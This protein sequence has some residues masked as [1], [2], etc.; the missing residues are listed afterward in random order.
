MGLFEN[1]IKLLT[2]QIEGT[3]FIISEMKKIGIEELPYAQSALK[4]FIDSKTMDIHYNKHYKTYVKKLND[5]L[6]KKDYGDLELEEIIKSISKF[7]TTIRNN[8]G[9]AFNHALFWKMLSPTKQLP[10]GK[11]AEKI[12]KEFNSYREFKTK[13]EEVA[14]ER[15][16]SGWVWL[17]L[18]KNNRLKI[19]ST[20]NQDNPLMNVVEGGGYP[21]LGLDI[22]EHAYYLRYQNKRDEYIKNFWNCVNWEFVNELYELKTNKNQ[23]LK[24]SY[25]FT[26]RQILTLLEQD[27]E[28]KEEKIDLISQL[29]NRRTRTPQ[30]QVP[31]CKLLEYRDSLTDD[32]I[33]QQFEKDFKTVLSFFGDVPTK[34]LNEIILEM[35]ESE[36]SVPVSEFLSTLSKI[37]SSPK[38]LKGKLRN[39]LMDLIRTENFGQ[40][41]ENLLSDIES[42]ASAQYEASFAGDEFEI[43]QTKLKLDYSCGESNIETLFTLIQDFQSGSKNYDTYFSAITNCVNSYLTS[44]TPQL[45]A[46]IVTLKPLYIETPSG[47][48]EV[49]PSN[50][51]IEVKYLGLSTDSYLSEFF[52]VF[53]QGILA[54]YKKTHG[55]TYNQLIQDLFLFVQEN[56]DDFL[57]RIKSQIGGIA[58][59]EYIIVPIKYIDLYWSNKGQKS[60]SELRLS[61]RFK[62]KPEKGEIETY[63]YTKGSDILQ[64]NTRGFSDKLLKRFEGKVICPR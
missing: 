51:H 45:K 47:R 28:E 34:M 17:I 30:N 32:E 53:K 27:E 64:K 35:F 13:F 20:P 43:K 54:D 44:E 26:K 25:V 6:S 24:E 12:K 29:C 16:G 8:G 1:K 48:T 2:E 62:L 38:Y 23:K 5:A 61:I 33:K 55:K 22:W 9:G 18:T 31:Y 4:K 42:S 19:M 37:V 57:E 60:C 7:P 59:N 46:D 11:I 52:A 36:Q 63:T 39:R 49:F 56:G 15:F 3:N 40:E 10:T 50:T 21:L 41:F 14:K 58:F